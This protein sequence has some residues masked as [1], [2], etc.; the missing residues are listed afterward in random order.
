MHLEI[1]SRNQGSLAH[2]RVGICDFFWA[3]NFVIRPKIYL[4]KNVHSF[5]K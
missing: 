3:L 2:K 1:R 5:F 4:N